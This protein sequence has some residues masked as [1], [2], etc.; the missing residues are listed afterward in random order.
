MILIKSL[1]LTLLI[2]EII[3]F[4]KIS[5]EIK[6]IILI[7]KKV[8]F[9]LNSK[10]NDNSQKNLLKLSRELFIISLKF[11]MYLLLFF[12]L[13]FL[14]NILD[15]KLYNFIFTINGSFYLTFVF[16]AYFFIRK[17]LNDKL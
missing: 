6:K 10:F 1:F 2:F 8:L 17:I 14:L 5:N 11:F 3:H 16:T 13:L 9:H 15:H 12:F 4:L 7:I